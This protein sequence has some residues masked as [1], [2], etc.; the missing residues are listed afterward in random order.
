MALTYTPSSAGSTGNPLVE[1]A[2]IMGG[3]FQDSNT[4]ASSD[5][6]GGKLWLWNSTSDVTDLVALNAVNDGIQLGVKPG[7]V[8][9]MVSATAASTAPK[10]QFGVFASP[11][12]A[13]TSGICLSSNVLSST[14]V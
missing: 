5:K 12:T 1:L 11:A 10:L 14:A 9:I 6:P 8:L 13:L 4:A 3:I 2:G 7:D